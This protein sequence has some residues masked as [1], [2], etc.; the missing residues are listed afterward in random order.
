M[1]GESLEHPPHLGVKP[2]DKRRVLVCL[3]HKRDHSHNGRLVPALES[4]VTGLAA[5]RELSRASSLFVDCHHGA[6]L[7]YSRHGRIYYRAA[8]VHYPLELYVVLVEVIEREECAVSAVF[9]VVGGIQICVDGELKAL[10]EQLLYCRELGEQGRLCVN[11]SS[12]PELA[13]PD[14]SG[15]GLLLPISRGVDH[16]V[17]RHDHYVSALIPALYFI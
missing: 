9:L 17:V 5:R 15:E 11:R 1:R 7:A 4:R 14:N 13:V 10:P 2:P 3:G 6:S 8:L 12:A 16:V